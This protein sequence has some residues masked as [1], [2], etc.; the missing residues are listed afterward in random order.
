MLDLIGKSIFGISFCACGGFVVF[1]TLRFYYKG[2]RS[3]N[4]LVTKGEIIQSDWEY[5]LNGD[6]P[7]LEFKLKYKFKINEIEYIGTRLFLMTYDF[8]NRNYKKRYPLKKQV[9]VYYNPNNP[10]DC[11]LEN[12]VNYNLF[13]LMFFGLIFFSIGMLF[14]LGVLDLI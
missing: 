2:K 14:I 7:D 1:M 8:D 13:T 4:W 10:N 3:L 11:V 9:D 12:G 5:V 6:A